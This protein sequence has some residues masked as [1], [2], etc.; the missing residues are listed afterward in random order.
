MAFLGRRRRDEI[1]VAADIAKVVATLS[2]IG[3]HDRVSLDR[4]SSAMTTLTR[5]GLLNL[6]ERPRGSSR[7]DPGTTSRSLAA[8]DRRRLNV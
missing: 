3:L 5:R 4:A 7:I 6:F 8:T 2:T 1:A